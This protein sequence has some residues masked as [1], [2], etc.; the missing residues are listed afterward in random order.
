MDK[1]RSLIDLA[2][3]SKKNA[4]VP[5]SK[6]KVG[7]AVLTSSGK[8]YTGSNIENISFGSSICAER[9]AL[10]KAISDG[11]RNISAIAVTSDSLDYVFPC[12][13][14]RQFI[15]EFI[16]DDM[17]IICCKSNGEYKKYKMTDMIPNM[18]NI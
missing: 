3:E 18:F 16:N 7:A 4:Y 2:M 6:F 15:A 14:C 8:I 12:G 10:A 9:V 17:E 13:I 11:E 1:Y 5:Y